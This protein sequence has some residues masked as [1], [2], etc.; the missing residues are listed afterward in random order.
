MGLRTILNLLE[1]GTVANERSRTWNTWRLLWSQ[2]CRHLQ[3]CRSK[4]HVCQILGNGIIFLGVVNIVTVLLYQGRMLVS[5]FFTSCFG[6]ISK[7]QQKNPQ[8]S[9]FKLWP[10]KTGGYQ[11]L[12]SMTYEG[13]TCCVMDFDTKSANCT[14]CIIINC[15]CT[16]FGIVAVNLIL[17][18]SFYFLFSSLN[19]F[20]GANKTAGLFW[21][22]E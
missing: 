5:I 20:L 8:F 13:K 4:S 16:D 15:L 19:K 7:F 3:R 10:C 17:N 14:F 21:S 22:S 2:H 6:Y 9:L 18:I 11:L 1:T 12:V